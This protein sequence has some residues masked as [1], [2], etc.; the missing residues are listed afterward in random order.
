MERL[1]INQNKK[2]EAVQLDINFD[3]K[4][5]ED[6]SN[7]EEKVKPINDGLDDFPGDDLFGRF[8]EYKNTKK[9]TKKSKSH[10]N[11]KT[12]GPK[13]PLFNPYK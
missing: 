4:N 11:P 12:D 7:T 2:P 13:N 6:I 1:N 9:E 10:F 8:A 5:Q 3:D